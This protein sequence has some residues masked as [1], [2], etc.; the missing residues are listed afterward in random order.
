M[1]PP[2]DRERVLAA[3]KQER[4]L[5]HLR[6]DF[7]Y[8]AEY[9]LRLRNPDYFLSDS[10]KL[11]CRYLQRLHDKEFDKL[12]IYAPSGWGKSS[13]LIFYAAWKL[14]VVPGLQ[15]IGASHKAEFAE[16]KISRPIQDLIREVTAEMGVNPLDEN[17]AEWRCSNKST[18]RATGVGAGILGER[19]HLGII[20]DPFGKM[21]DAKSPK[22]RDTTYDWYRA[23]FTSRLHI[24]NSQQILMHQRVHLDDLAARLMEEEGETWEVCFLPARFEG[25]NYKGEPIKEDELGRTRV[26]QSIW[27]ENWTE[28]LL[29][30]REKEAGPYAW[31]SMYQQRPQP[32]G[33]T[34]F[35]PDRIPVVE[36]EKDLLPAKRL[37]MAFDYGASRK[38]DYSVGILMQENGG[39][40]GWSIL[41]L[42]RKQTT[43][44]EL[45]M[46]IVNFAAKAAE[47]YGQHGFRIFLP[48][49]PAAGG[50]HMVAAFT[51]ALAGYLV[52]AGREGGD[53]EKRADPFA[54][55]VNAGNVSMLAAPWNR[56]FRQELEDFPGG[57]NDDQVDAAATAFAHLIPEPPRVLPPAI[58][59]HPMFAR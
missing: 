16:N 41:D 18:Y 33:G 17:K 37:M 12:M 22:V 21:A 10:H 11:L 29:G 7:T 52:D 30:V 3:L 23:D 45:H 51:K 8:F 9:A 15:L 26:G 36:V 24:G 35:Y 44:D 20:D 57:K 14:C 47:K 31:A 48:Q 34:L 4:H 55:Q 46:L 27:P 28:P 19:A 39:P 54:A 50:V 6:T 5:R 42:I 56:A 40:G 25:L 2:I 13:I 49:D 1:A 59:Y 58:G 43:P 53:K 32:L 38:G